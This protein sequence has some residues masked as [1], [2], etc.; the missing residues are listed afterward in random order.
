MSAHVCR[1]GPVIQGKVCAWCRPG[2]NATEGHS[3]CAP[4][5]TRQLAAA[6]LSLPQ[7]RDLE[8]ARTPLSPK[9]QSHE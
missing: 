9:S 5:A 3:I 7:R 8:A 2:V 4:C 6:G 1:S